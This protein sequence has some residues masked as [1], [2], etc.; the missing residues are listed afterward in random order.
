MKRK[1]KVLVWGVIVLLY[2]LFFITSIVQAHDCS[3]LSDCFN[4][5]PSSAA[6][7]ILG[8]NLAILV[9]SLITEL[10][11]GLAA[12]AGLATIAGLPPRPPIGEQYPITVETRGG[13][14]GIGPHLRDYAI[15]V[16]VRGGVVYKRGI[17]G[18]S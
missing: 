15:N 7:A 18:R 1:Y 14:E 12:I 4:N 10:I 16:E 6:L 5:D 11:A 9:P 8:L 3:G 17:K 2:L 13:I